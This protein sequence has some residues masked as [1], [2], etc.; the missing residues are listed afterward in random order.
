MLQ[1]L[2]FTLEALLVTASK[3]Q[4]KTVMFDNILF[5]PF[6]YDDCRA[7]NNS[8][9][10]AYS[11]ALLLYWF[12][13]FHD[14][15]S[16]WI[17]WVSKRRRKI[18]QQQKHRQVTEIN[19]LQH[20]MILSCLR[21]TFRFEK[22]QTHHQFCFMTCNSFSVSQAIRNQSTFFPT[23]IPGKKNLSIFSQLAFLSEY[24]II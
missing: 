12:A 5:A 11:V 3:H 20:Q 16:R 23:L 19:N 18:I 17:C 15:H 2:F 4:N 10:R 7:C 1:E 21:L 9:R 8:S 6:C 14:V 22:F 24:L 13:T